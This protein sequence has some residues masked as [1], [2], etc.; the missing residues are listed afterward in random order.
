ML[1]TRNKRFTIRT[2]DLRAEQEI[3]ERNKRFTSGT[4]DLRAEL[5]FYERN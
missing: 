5:G 4:R 1:N 3:Y 2:R